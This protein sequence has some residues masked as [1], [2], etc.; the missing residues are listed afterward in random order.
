MASTNLRFNSFCGVGELLMTI[1]IVTF[2]ISRYNHNF[3]IN[4]D[5]IPYKFLFFFVFIN[6]LGFVFTLFFERQICNDLFYENVI[7]T[8]SAYLLNILNALALFLT[9]KKDEV[10]YI[11]KKILVY[12]NIIYLLTFTTLYS[13]LVAS[14]LDGERFLGYS[15]N[16]NQHGVLL[17]AIPFIAIYLF[18]NKIIKTWFFIL[19]VL[20][21]SLLTFLIKSDAVYYSFIFSLFLF[22]LFIMKSFKIEVKFLLILILPTFFYFFIFDSIM[23]FIETTNNDQGQANVRYILWLNGILA[24]LESPLIGLGPGSFSGFSRPFESV[25]CHNTIIDLLTNMGLVGLFIYLFFLIKIFKSFYTNNSIFLFLMLFSV[26][27]FSLFHNI[28]RHP[29]FWLVL[30]TLYNISQNNTFMKS[31]L[32]KINPHVRN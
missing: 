16:P 4:N 10:A 2:L 25:E 30:I 8:F 9:I 17:V 13:S 12:F 21:S 3:S 31:V 24:F 7:R 29:T 20:T 15:T 11:F 18:K 22:F 19:T 28:L 14:I 6:F 32:K 26:I 27:I 23:V 1:S 5:R